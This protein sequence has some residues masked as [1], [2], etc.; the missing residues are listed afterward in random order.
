[1][2][3]FDPA[4]YIDGETDVRILVECMPHYTDD[5]FP[6]RVVLLDNDGEE[7]TE[8]KFTPSRA[9]EQAMPIARLLSGFVP[10]ADTHKLAEGMRIAAIKVWAARN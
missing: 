6:V 10:R 7:L 8:L 3:V 4:E 1:M 5:Q 2:S 9:I